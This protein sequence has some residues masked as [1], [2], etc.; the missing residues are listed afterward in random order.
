V[1]STGKTFPKGS[2]DTLKTLHA[3]GNGPVVASDP[4]SM[5]QSEVLASTSAKDETSPAQKYP[6]RSSFMLESV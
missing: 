6:S 5:P 2:R 4:G 1:T 3:T